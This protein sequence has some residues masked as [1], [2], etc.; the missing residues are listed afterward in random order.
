MAKTLITRAWN[1]RRRPL[2]NIPE[3]G[4]DMTSGPTVLEGGAAA[5]RPAAPSCWQLVYAFSAF[6]ATTLDVFGW[7]NGTNTNE[8]KEHN[9]ASRGAQMWAHTRAFWVL[10]M[11]THPSLAFWLKPLTRWRVQAAVFPCPCHTNTHTY[12]RKELPY[13]GVFGNEGQ[14]TIRHN[15][16]SSNHKNCTFIL[17]RCCAKHPGSTS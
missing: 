4:V 16:E 15:Y 11:L 14:C 5:A 2:D 6:R 7:R 17:A 8:K 3:G 1:W 13:F 10:I 12:T 9:V